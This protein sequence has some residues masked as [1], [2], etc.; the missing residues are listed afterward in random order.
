[1]PKRVIIFDTTLRD[2]EQSPGVNLNAQEKLEIA[3]QL[4]R[5]GV[6]VIEAGFPVSSPGDFEAVRLIAEKVEGPT[7]AGLA[8][9]EDVDIDAA[10]EAV[11]VARKPRIHTFLATSPIHMQHKLQ[12]EP[13]QVLARAVAAVKRAKGY[14]EDVEFS[15]EDA[16]RSEP[17][18]LYRV[19]EAVIAAGA[20]TVNIPD[21]V[22]YT[23]PEE[24]AELIAGI[25]R[26]VPNIDQAVISVHCHNDLG[27]A[28]ANSLA[29]I[30]NG[31]LQVEC[32]VNGIGERA[33]NCSLEEVVMALYTR[34]RFF[35]AVSNINYGEIYRTSRMVASLTGMSVQ[36]NKAIVGKNA[37][38]HESGIHQDGVLKERSTYE[39]M[40]PE[41]VG[42]F[43]D[44]IVLGK[45]SGRHA[46]RDRL[47]QLGYELSDDELKRTFKQF[48]LLADRKKE[49]SRHDLEALVEQELKL[50]PTIYQLKS[51]HF[52]S[53]TEVLP[54]ATV[55]LQV[56]DRTHIEASIGDGPV[57]AALHAVDRITE[58]KSTLNEFQIRATTAGKDA[59]GEVNVK[60]ESGGKLFVGRGVSTDVVEASVRAYIDA[61]NKIAFEQQP[62]KK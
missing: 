22:G 26:N 37:F 43:Q 40:N 36:P 41:M 9:A 20:T 46:F 60:V 2:G 1:M 3:R 21:T 28:V 23:V 45:L 58:L 17:A 15:C 51:L 12:L 42:I 18:F 61:A 38:A 14:V 32:A 25:K 59:L 11:K 48:K 29:A 52:F 7:I 30:M 4:A 62:K 50:V 57:D 27:L 10:W 54:T 6:D 16:G 47:Q 49:I 19:L 44:G 31:A 55:A 34:Q 35:D 13:D 8:R 24:F 5:L 33:G 39:I 53:G 56:G